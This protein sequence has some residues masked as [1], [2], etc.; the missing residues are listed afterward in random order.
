MAH[1]SLP[2]PTHLR[3]LA[4]TK[5]LDPPHAGHG[6]ALGSGLPGHHHGRPPGEAL[7]LSPHEIPYPELLP[8]LE[9][10][11]HMKESQ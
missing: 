9:K 6:L 1:E 2:G 8:I 11:N 3:E 10:K 5:P 4:I 7:D